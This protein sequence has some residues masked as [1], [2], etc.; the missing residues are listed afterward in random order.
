MKR[1]LALF[2]AVAVIAAPTL[3]LFSSTQAGANIEISYTAHQ[4]NIEFV[5]DGHATLQPTGPFSPGDELIIRE[6]FLQG[7]TN[8]GYDNVICTDTFNDN[9]F[10]NAVLAF[11]G[12]GDMTGTVLLRG[13]AATEQGPGVF[14][15]AITGG[16]FS[17]R[18]AH[19]DAH[20]V[21]QSNGDTA[22]TINLVTQ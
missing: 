6:D 1:R 3:I 13:G 7:T 12:K 14:D 2:A 19:G 20:A 5:I 4:T 10:C 17:Y 15:A 9:L 21:A 18:N 22:W 8:I 16:T 11:T